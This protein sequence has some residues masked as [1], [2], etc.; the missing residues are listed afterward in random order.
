MIC[1]LIRY[2][3]TQELAQKQVVIDRYLPKSVG[4]LLATYLLVIRPWMIMLKP[5]L[6][7]LKTR[8]TTQTPAR[9]YTMFSQQFAAHGCGFNMGVKNW[10][11]WAKFVF[12]VLKFDFNWL[13]FGN[14]SNGTF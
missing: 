11:H 13:E 10:R 2:N 8:L 12:K 4:S 7:E 1:L 5:N 9:Y 6:A 3:K 14:N